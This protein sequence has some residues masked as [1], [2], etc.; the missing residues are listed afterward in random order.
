MQNRIVKLALALGIA[1]ATTALPAAASACPNGPGSCQLPPNGNPG[2]FP[3]GVPQHRPFTTTVSEKV[4]VKAPIYVWRQQYD[5][6]CGQYRRVP[7]QV[8]VRPEWRTVRRLV[9][10]FWYQPWGR[11]VYRDHRGQLRPLPPQQLP[12]Y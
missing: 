8:G 12:R 4:L 5:P 11:Y 10:A 6:S 7:V 1:I 2:P 3:P 9:T